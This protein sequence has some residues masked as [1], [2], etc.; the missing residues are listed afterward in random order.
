[1][2]TRAGAFGML[3][4]VAIDQ[5]EVCLDPA[6]GRADDAAEPQSVRGLDS[7]VKLVRLTD[8]FTGANFFR[9][10]TVSWHSNCN[11]LRSM[12]EREGF[13]PPI[14]VKVCPLSRRIVSTTHAPLRVG[15]AVR[16]QLT[17]VSKSL[18]M[19]G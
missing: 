17:A 7:L 9:I 4:F 12:A 1:M 10:T 8:L 3:L 11:K 18:T 2:G 5:D 13:E 19:T 15:Q 14:P 6:I 16:H